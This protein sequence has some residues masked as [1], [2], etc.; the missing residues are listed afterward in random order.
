LASASLEKRRSNRRTQQIREHKMKKWIAALSTLACSSA[1][2]QGDP[3]FNGMVKLLHCS[4]AHRVICAEEYC[5][6]LSTSAGWNNIWI[7][8][9]QG[10]IGSQSP[11]NNR[12]SLPV[13]I[14]ETSDAGLNKI[15]FQKLEYG[16]TEIKKM[17]INYYPNHGQMTNVRFGIVSKPTSGEITKGLTV[18]RLV[19]SGQC[20][21]Q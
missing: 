19:E 2:A 21:I 4:I 10:L 6:D 8:I 1:V 12:N 13:R 3:T 15:L 20:E 5:S 9:Q 11:L 7:D 16:G 17:L 14:V 18:D